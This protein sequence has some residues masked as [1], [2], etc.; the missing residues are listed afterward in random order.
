MP[1]VRQIIGVCPQKE[2][3][4]NVLTAREH[5]EMVCNVRGIVGERK[6]REVDDKLKQVK[7]TNAADRYAK[8][9]SGGMKRRLALAMAMIGDPLVLFLDEPNAGVDPGYD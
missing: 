4:W 8:N 6:K 9:F 5:L 2:I 7:L 1:S 3:I